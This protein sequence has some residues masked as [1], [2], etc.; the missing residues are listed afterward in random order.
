M[1]PPIP[2]NDSDRL[3][4]LRSLGVL[5]TPPE[6]NYD[7][8]TKLAAE[9]CRVP[10]ALISLVDTDRQWFKSRIGLEV[11]ETSRA[12]SF[13]AHAI[14][15]P[16]ELLIVPDAHND[17]RFSDNP[18]VLGEPHLRFYAGAPLVTHDGWALGT[19]CV[20]DH[21]PR[22]L[23]PAQLEALAILRRHVVNAIELRRVVEKQGEV[24]HEL[25]RTRAALN[26]ARLDAERATRAKAEFLA[27]MSH[28]IRTPMN[29]VIGMTTLLRCTA[30]TPE[31]QESVDTIQASGDHLLTVINDILDFS[32]IE[33]G[34]LEIESAPFGIADCVRSAVC[35]LAARANEKGV[36][37]NTS[38]GPE[39]P[40]C[41]VGDATRLRQILVNLLSNAVKFTERGAVDVAIQARTFPDRRVELRC[42]VRDTGI[43]IPADRMGRLF[44]EFSQVDAS[45][46]RRYGGTGL[47]LVISK[48]LAEMQGGSMEVE[49]ELGR[50]S[51]FRFTIMTYVA[52]PA[53]IPATVRSAGQSLEALDSGFAQLF[54][55]RILVA[56]DNQVNQRVITRTL[57]KLGYTVRVVD[58]G[59]A[60]L[61][62]LL[63]EPFDLV[64]MDVEMPE[65]DGPGATR[66]IRAILPAERQPV[67]VAM[68]AHA[69]AGNRAEFLSAG[70]NDYLAKPLQLAEL[71]RVLS[72]WRELAVRPT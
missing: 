68:T 30:L 10:M 22:E 35:L 58:D 5:D 20:L 12:S 13:C 3:A 29:A 16:N 72:T 70:M 34:K 67:I 59:R 40:P 21:A 41:L 64:L 33:S 44:Q 23:T 42:S 45:T 63:G 65:L 56:E 60:A 71:T 24:I 38:I 18:L 2:A 7:E 31:Q 26:A 19:L 27:S 46:T 55:A 43:G 48:R 53:A 8:L 9:I 51:C 14:N 54:P 47:G 32:K 61:T 39:V 62:A 52:L 66:E 15:Q 4:V 28:E 25:E 6:P 1:H 49:S 69:M 50:G 36:T 11:P 17:P 37:L 57:N